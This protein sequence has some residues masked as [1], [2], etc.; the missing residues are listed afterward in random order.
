MTDLALP[1][2]L[3][4]LDELREFVHRSL[5]RHENLLQDQSPLTELPL[6][7]GGKHCGLQFT[8]HGP[9]TLRLS[10]IWAADLNVIYFYDSRGERYLKIPLRYRLKRVLDAA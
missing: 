10:A 2:D 8:V 3:F 5:C 9:R 1:M 4:S 6:L 7:R